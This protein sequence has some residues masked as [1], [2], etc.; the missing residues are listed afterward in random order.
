MVQEHIKKIISSFLVETELEGP[1]MRDLSGRVVVVT[2][3][4]SGIGKAITRVLIAKGAFVISLSRRGEE[5]KSKSYVAL[6]V[7]V[8]KKREVD[9]AVVK[10][11]GK[12]GKIDVLINC[13]GIFSFREFEMITEREY[14]KVMDTNVK[15]MFLL[16]E[17]VVPH[18][19]KG[20]KGLIINIGSKISHNTNV[21]PKKV[22]YAVSKYAVEGFS[23]A[24]GREL[25][26]SGIRVTCLM[27]GTVN[28]FVSLKSKQ[29]LTS[30]NVG[31]VVAMLML[32]EDVNFESIIM[33]SNRQN[34]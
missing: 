6:K 13:A 25:Q 32:L 2:G 16:S 29:F 24:L 23:L 12:Y 8:T 7:N 22:L 17:A 14:D 15:G 4:T 33:K 5:L 10:I 31:F 28:T 26:K 1:L 27:L 20:K 11:I 19:K 3:G 9:A 34:I 18:M 21:A 30:E